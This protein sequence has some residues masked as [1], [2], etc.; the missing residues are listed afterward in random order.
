MDSRFVGVP[1][2]GQVPSVAVV[3]DVMRAFTVTAWAFALGAEKIVLAESLEEALAH[4]ARHPD[5][6]TVKDGPAV[7]GSTW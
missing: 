7:P 6:L 3:V 5:W 1:E 4:K 2:L